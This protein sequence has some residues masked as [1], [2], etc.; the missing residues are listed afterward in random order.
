MV[1]LEIRSQNE[2]IVSQEPN[3]F[4]PAE[5]KT[6]LDLDTFHLENSSTSRELNEMDNFCTRL[7]AGKCFLTAEKYNI[8][9]SAV[10]RLSV[11][12]DTFNKVIIAP[13]FTPTEVLT[14]SRKR[15]KV[16]YCEIDSANDDERDFGEDSND[17]E[18]YQPTED[19]LLNGSCSSDN[20]SECGS[21]SA[22][23]VLSGSPEPEASFAE[24]RSQIESPDTTESPKKKGKKRVR[25][26][27]TW[28]K[29]VRKD[30]R[31]SGRSYTS[32]RGKV[33]KEKSIKPPCSVQC[34]LKCST[35][36]SEASRKEIFANYWKLGSLQRQRDFIGCC[37]EP[38]QL[39]YRRIKA[40][41]SKEPRRQ[42]RIAHF[43]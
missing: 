9:F 34:S 18:N 41:A 36:I 11:P 23:P 21:D 37:V 40:D 29:A 8:K 20:C 10:Y 13:S 43:I 22:L 14:S 39:K 25:R 12:D 7:N 38:L 5:E 26:P 6:L 30:L 33:V 16:S 35:K 19:E 17:S 15:V 2:E 31:N 4:D 42:N 27:E 32:A 24:E 28:K 1:A 3:P